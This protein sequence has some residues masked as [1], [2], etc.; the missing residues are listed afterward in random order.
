VPGA[1]ATIKDKFYGSA[2]SS[3]RRTFPVLSKLAE[4]HMSKI[5]K[6]DARN[7]SGYFQRLIGEITSHLSPSD[8]PFPIRLTAEEQSFFTLGYYQQTSFRKEKITNDNTVE[9][10]N[11]DVAA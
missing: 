8:N 6:K 10:E 7:L 3:P 11:D 1:N 5:G 4:I 2:L 9:K